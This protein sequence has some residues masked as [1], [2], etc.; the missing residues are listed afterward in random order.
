M[1]AVEEREAA[2][3]VMEDRG[4]P[5]EDAVLLC[6]LVHTIERDGPRWTCTCGHQPRLGESSLRH[7]AHQVTE[8]LQR[9][10]SLT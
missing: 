10:G 2:A 3:R 7:Q 4:V 5:E 1:S 9:R 6:L 8:L